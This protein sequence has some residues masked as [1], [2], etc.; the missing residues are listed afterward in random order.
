MKNA[1]I[2][3]QWLAILFLTAAMISGNAKQVDFRDLPSFNAI[4]SSGSVNVVLEKGDTEQAR[5][6]SENL[7][8]KYII[9]EVV[10]HTL[11]IYIK[12]NHLF[13]NT[14]RKTVYVKYKR[15]DAI[16]NSG[17]GDLQCNTFL[18]AQG[19]TIKNSGSGD[20]KLKNLAVKD[21]I[22][23][24]NGGSGDIYF[25]E[26]NAN[27]FKARLSGSGD[28]RIDGGQASDISL[29]IS[30]SGD[31]SAGNLKGKN[32]QATTSGSGDIKTYASE[33][34][35]VRISGSGD[36]GFY[37]NPSQKNVSKSG[38]GDARKL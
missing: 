20:I 17:S 19:F 24:T 14:G 25:H 33:S 29:S 26:V 12:D 31:I 21:E 9:T 18:E 23:I 16:A 34:I 15:L 32:V 37:G 2:K 35:S 11:K 30:G 27:R 22:S 6:E 7:E 4:S 38:S 36:V 13:G 28:L 3:R 10:N 5:V 1:T 8:V